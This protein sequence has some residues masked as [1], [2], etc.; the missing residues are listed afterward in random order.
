MPTD[1]PSRSTCARPMRGGVEQQVD[2]VVV[3][4]VDLVD[5]EHAAVRGGEQAGLVGA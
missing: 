1:T 2:E 5:V 4:Q 3:Q